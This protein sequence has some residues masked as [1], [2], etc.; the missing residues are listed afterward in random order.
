MIAGMPDWLEAS[1]I[2]Y[3]A[4]EAFGGLG[5][6]GLITIIVVSIIAIITF[7]W[8]FRETGRRE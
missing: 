3:A 8:V 5:K 6:E 2:A 7:V 4:G 1:A